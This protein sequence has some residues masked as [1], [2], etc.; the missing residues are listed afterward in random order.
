M[1]TK[2]ARYAVEDEFHVVM[3]CPAYREMRL[4]YASLFDCASGVEHADKATA[5]QMRVFMDQQ[6]P[7][8]AAF[9]YQCMSVRQSLPD[10]APYLEAAAE[11]DGV[12]M[13]M[14]ESDGEYEAHIIRSVR[15]GGG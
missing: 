2:C 5:W 15:E 4:Q 1:C 14:M 9:V 12:F 8:L 3:E 10:M 7:V 13:D 11:G 6:P